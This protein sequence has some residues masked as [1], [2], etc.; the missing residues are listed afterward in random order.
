MFSVRCGEAQ[1]IQDTHSDPLS[2]GDVTEEVLKEVYTPSL[3]LL[4]F[5]D[6]GLSLWRWP[7][8]FNDCPIRNGITRDMEKY[9][10]SYPGRRTTVL[11]PI[12][13]PYPLDVYDCN[14]AHSSYLNSWIVLPLPYSCFL[15][16]INKSSPPPCLVIPLPSLP[17]F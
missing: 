4:A 16:R 10:M 2:F 1:Q 12:L 13:I 8:H 6:K 5:V 15:Q 11:Y 7:W 17:L 14:W 9:S 3:P